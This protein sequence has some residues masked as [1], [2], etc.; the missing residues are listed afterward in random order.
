MRAFEIFAY[1]QLLDF[2]TTL[3]GFRFGAQEASPFIR[4][5]MQAGPVAG[6]VASKLGAFAIAGACMWSGRARVIEWINYWYAALVI[7]NLRIIL[8]ALTA[9]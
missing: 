3:V 1:L 8:S 4:L 7:W 2:A 5:L 6:L 9:S